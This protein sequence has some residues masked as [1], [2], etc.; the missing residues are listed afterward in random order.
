M[1]ISQLIALIIAFIL[2]LCFGDPDFRFHPIRII[3]NY[4]SLSEKVLRKIFPK[5]K[6]GETVAGGILVIKV[7]FVSFAVPF[8]ILF[9]SYRLNRFFGIGVE[10]VMCYFLL[11]AR[12]LSDAALKV[13]KPLK[14]GDTETARKNVSMIVGRDTESLDDVGITK[15][16]VET[17]AENTSDGIA[18]PIIYMAIGGGVLGFMYKAVNTMDSMVGYKNDR[19]INFGKIAARLDDVANFI[20]SRISAYLMILSAYIL[21][22]DGKGA[23][24]IHKRDCRRHASPNSAQTESATAGALGIQLAGNAY[25]FGKL[26]K[27]PFIGDEKRDIEYEDIKKSIKL[28]YLTSVITLIL[29]ALIK[30]IVGV[31]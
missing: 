27:K 16:A 3:G 14:I 1:V 21:R 2:D 20:P 24:K 18:A 30:L 4:I 11:A 13:Y 9:F 10:S 6:Y 25:Y 12:S 31:L 29:C 28:M 17:V 22:F 15:A 5:T 8:L 7:L 26:Y 23:F 19:Y